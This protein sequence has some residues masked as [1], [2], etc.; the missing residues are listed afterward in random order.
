MPLNAASADQ[1]YMILIDTS[2][3]VDHHLVPGNG[4]S[5]MLS[6]SAVGGCGLICFVM[7]AG[8][9]SFVSVSQRLARHSQKG[10]SL[11]NSS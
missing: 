1:A 4:F 2:V 5:L 9:S 11:K 7:L 10:K 3:W 8:S 6:T